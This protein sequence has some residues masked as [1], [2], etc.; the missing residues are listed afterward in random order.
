MRSFE[1][2][3]KPSMNRVNNHIHNTKLIALYCHQAIAQN[4]KACSRIKTTIYSQKGIL[5]VYNRLFLSIGRPFVTQQQNIPT[6]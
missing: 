1:E 4:E 6:F 5:E 3:Q 2:P